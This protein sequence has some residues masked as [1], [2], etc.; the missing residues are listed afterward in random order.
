MALPT[1]APVMDRR[2]FVTA[3]KKTALVNTDEIHEAARTFSGLTPYN[4][5]W[6][7]NEVVHLLKRTMFG[8]SPDDINYFLA[9]GMNQSVDALLT[10]SATPPL[11]PV[12]NYNNNNIPASDPDYNI[13]MGQTWVTINTTDADGQRRNSLKAWWMGLMIN[14][15]RN[16]REKM[17]LF[18]HNHFST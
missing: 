5:S 17:T 11:P 14:Q 4:G 18:W 2:E 8:S 16:I 1:K 15:E 9:L 3:G 10:V 7:S 13:P 12:K 6:T